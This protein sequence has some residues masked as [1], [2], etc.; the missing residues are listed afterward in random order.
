MS[1]STATSPVAFPAARLRFMRD[2]RL[3]RMA[4]AGDAVAFTLLYRRHHPALHRYASTLVRHE[5][6]AQD[7]VQSAMT[8][9]LASL[10]DG[11][12]DAPARPWL[13]RIVHNEAVDLLRRRRRTEELDAAA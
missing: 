9:A 13:F 3:L 1:G 7:V 10:D 12:P 2:D 4:G 11:A 6:D 5:Q 8:K